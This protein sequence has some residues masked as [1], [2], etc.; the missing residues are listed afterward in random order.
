M[1]TSGA[2]IVAALVLIPVMGPLATPAVADEP[3]PIQVIFD[4]HMDPLNAI[5]LAVRPN[6]YADWRDAAEWALD[7]CEPRGAR[8]TFLS[9]GEYMEYTLE[10]PV[11]WPLI[12][13]LFNG[14]GTIGT[15]S[16][17]EKKYGP[18]DWRNLPPNATMQQIVELWHDHVDAVDAVITAA[19]G[20]TNPKEIRAINNTRGAHV[21]SDDTARIALMA[22]FGFTMHQQGPCEQFYAYFEHYPMNPFRP[23]G[24]HYLTHDP[25][26][27]VVTSPFGPVLGRDAVHFGILQDMRLPAMKARFLLTLLNWL[28]DVYIRSTGRV[29]NFGWAAHGSDI[30]PGKPT[31]AAL[32]PMLDWLKNNFVDQSAGGRKAM[33]FSS[34]RRSRDLYY[35]WEAAHPGGVS[36]SYP[37]SETNWCSIHTCCRSC[38]TWSAASMRRPTRSVRFGCTR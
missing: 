10:D 34:A 1:R 6:V 21:P 27:P 30:V 28:D 24:Q 13:R 9:V 23:W 36:F 33:V 16:H 11:S 35:A 7:V 3:P 17:K 22:Q 2:M 15:H 29:W 12:E 37:A 31:R 19:L 32:G 5:P 14:G 26:G 18:H 8:I 4:L 38:A 25:S 20:V